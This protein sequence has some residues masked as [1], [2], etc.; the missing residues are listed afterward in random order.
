[1]STQF[2][3]GVLSAKT[4]CT[5]DTIRYY[6]RIKL[7]PLVI[8]TPGGRRLYDESAV[9]QLHFIRQARELG[10]TLEQTHV[11]L[12]LSETRQACGRA[13]GMIRAQADTLK[14]R[15][16]ALKTMERRL[17]ALAD[18]C[19]LCDGCHCAMQAGLTH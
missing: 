16:A 10:F 18:N 3:I 17:R 7:L 12:N 6:E 2:T 4:G 19:Q 1:M 11:L 14:S 8:R 13:A 5:P 15:I 9:R